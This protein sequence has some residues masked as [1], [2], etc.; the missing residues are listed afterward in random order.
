MRAETLQTCVRVRPLL[1]FELRRGDTEVASVPSDGPPGAVHAMV[2][3][4]SKGQTMLQR[5]AFDRSFDPTV[6]QAE[7]W[8]RSGVAQLVDDA[9]RGYRCTVFAYGQ[10][11]SGKTFT[12]SGDEH[13]LSSRT[14]GDLVENG[15]SPSDGLV[16]RA[17]THLYERVRAREAARGESVVVQASYCEVYNEHVYDLLVPGEALPVRQGG[18]GGRA[19][20]FFVQGL[21]VVACT[22]LED[23]IAVMLQGHRTRSTGSHEMNKDSSR[24]HAML[25]LRIEIDG[26]PSG[27]LCFTDLAGSER[28]K[29]TRLGNW[30]VAGGVGI[31]E[32]GKRATAAAAMLK[33]TSNIN[34]SLMTLGKVI[35]AL[36]AN[37]RGGSPSRGSRSRSRSRSASRGAQG[38]EER[39]HVPFRDSVLTKLLSEALSGNSRTLMIACVSPSTAYLDETLSTLQYATRA[40]GV[41]TRPAPEVVDPLVRELIAL[42]NEVR[43]EK[44]RNSDLRAV[45]R[46]HKKESRLEQRGGIARAEAAEAVGGGGGGALAEPAATAVTSSGGRAAE[47]ALARS[48]RR[49]IDDGFGYTVEGVDGGR[50]NDHI[51]DGLG[52]FGFGVVVSVTKEDWKQRALGAEAQCKKLH[53]RIEHLESIFLDDQLVGSQT[54]RSSSSSSTRQRR[55]EREARH[56][57]G[58]FDFGV[59]LQ[60][61]QSRGAQQDAEMESSRAR[62]EH[63]LRGAAFG[64]ARRDRDD[65]PGEHHRFE[66]H[67]AETAALDSE[68][69]LAISL[70]RA[71]AAASPRVSTIAAPLSGGGGGRGRAAGAGGAGFGSGFGA[72][73]ALSASTSRSPPRGRLSGRRSYY[74]DDDAAA[75]EEEE[76]GGTLRYDDDDEDGDEDDYFDDSEDDGADAALVAAL[77][78]FSQQYESESL[79][80]GDDTSILRKVGDASIDVDSMDELLPPPPAT[81]RR[82]TAKSAPPR[83]TQPEFHAHPHSQQRAAK[84]PQRGTVAVLAAEALELPRGSSSDSAGFASAAAYSRPS[85]GGS[86]MSS[87]SRSNRKGGRISLEPG[88]RVRIR[89]VA[90]GDER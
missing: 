13:A 83:W 66:V 26:Q 38:G 72:A 1:D 42:R 18:G 76:E 88:G 70:L 85:S 87:G 10:T 64:A 34:R 15:P 21:C 54:T 12:M 82:T 46:A 53:L 62:E 48:R 32:G 90:D 61:Q 4:P 36:A 28:L 5:F 25:T 35:A 27:R 11:G 45:V 80:A 65:A 33:E 30:A 71:A 23:A 41:E 44:L 20:E 67:E 79:I 56:R 17:L 24:S 8:A 29:D 9:L 7:L 75:E 86:S 59:E 55:R 81:V 43:L 73:P 58:D 50:E 57:E 39:R 6:T 37:G 2:A 47:P 60:V 69:D 89:R 22:T 52:G 14:E 68:R 49:N 78:G 40:G 19:K 3:A 84:I 74:D 63:Q 77:G 16:P 31:D 51:E